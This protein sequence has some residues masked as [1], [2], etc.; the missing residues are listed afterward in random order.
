MKHPGKQGTIHARAVAVLACLVL[1]FFSGPLYSQAGTE[2]VDASE[3]VGEAT[4]TVSAP[5]KP[6]G[7]GEQ[8]GGEGAEGQEGCAMGTFELLPGESRQELSNEVSENTQDARTL[9]S[10]L[11]GRSYTFFGRIEPEYAAYFNGVLDDD[12]EFH[13]RRVRAGAVGVLSDR[14]SYK[15]EFDLTDGSNSFSDFYLKWDTNLLGTLTVGNQRVAQNL[16]AMTGALS[17]LFMER[18]LPVTT[19]S[20]GRRLGVS[21]DLYFRRFG[22]HAVAFTSDPNNDAGKYGGSLRVI[23]NPI[24]SDGGIAHVGFS[25][26]RERMDRD[27]RYRTRPESHATDIRL[28]D[29]GDYSDVEYQDILGIEIAGAVGSMTGRIEGFASR[30]EREN[31]KDSEFYGAYVEVGRFL[32]GQEFRYRDGKFVRPKFEEGTRAWEAGVRASWVDLDDDEV[33]GGEQYNLGL[34][35]NWYPRRNFRVQ[36]NLIYYDVSRDMGDEN[37]WIAQSRVQFNW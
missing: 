10:L 34:A 31:S 1:L 37:G 5:C 14:L 24:R 16:S 6:S 29:T 2:N 22:V 30:W 9:R 33:R 26:V 17:L 27:A 8:A 32:T 20:L 21:Q 23:T 19:F 13:L 3:P 28:V 36:F 7:D 11:L 12:D 35:L 25:L 4:E 18:P 15:A